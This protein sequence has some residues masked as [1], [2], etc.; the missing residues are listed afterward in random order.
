MICL[1]MRNL[2]LR[3]NNHLSRIIEL[4]TLPAIIVETASLA[5][6]APTAIGRN[7]Q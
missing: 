5:G 4:E 1:Q 7:R 6:P 2:R 3:E